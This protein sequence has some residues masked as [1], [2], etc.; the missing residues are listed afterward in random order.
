MLGLFRFSFH[1]LGKKIGLPELSTLQLFLIK[2][3]RIQLPLF[4]PRRDTFYNSNP[5]SFQRQSVSTLPTILLQ[6]EDRLR[7]HH[8]SWQGGC[9]A[10]QTMWLVHLVYHVGA[11]LK[12]GMNRH[13]KKSRA[14][15]WWH[16]RHNH[17]EPL[18]A[19]VLTTP[20]LAPHL[21]QFQALEY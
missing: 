20:P 7:G 6:K 13:L 1:L 16:S 11:R 5:Q 4:I 3:P 9:S 12:D 18:R 21:K 2:Q 8:G 19:L 10:S 14:V 15:P 17:Q